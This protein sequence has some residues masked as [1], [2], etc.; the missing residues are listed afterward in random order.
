[1]D[2][3]TVKAGRYTYT[4]NSPYNNANLPLSP[5]GLM[6]PVKLVETP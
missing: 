5:S 3:K 4:P 6:G 1:M 2:G